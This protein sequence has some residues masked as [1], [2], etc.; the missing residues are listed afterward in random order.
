[1]AAQPLS[2]CGWPDDAA[3]LGGGELALLD[4]LMPTG[5]E[6][7]ASL[8]L[9]SGGEGSA[10]AHAPAAPLRCLDPSHAA[11]CGLCLAP[12]PEGEEALYQLRAACESQGEGDGAGPSG[13][14]RL[15]AQLLATAEWNSAPAR[16]ALAAAEEARGDPARVAL[17]LRRKTGKALLKSHMLLMVRAWGY[18]SDLWR[19]RGEAGGR[20]KRSRPASDEAPPRQASGA[21]A[22]PRPPGCLLEP[23]SLAPGG[24]P[25]AL[26]ALW[27]PSAECFLG[28]V[29]REA[30]TRAGVAFYN[31]EIDSE[32]AAFDA[33]TARLGAE[34]AKLEA[35]QASWSAAMR[36]HLTAT[37]AASMDDV[38]ARLALPEGRLPLCVAAP[39]S[40]LDTVP[41]EAGAR[42]LLAAAA[43]LEAAWVERRESAQRALGDNSSLDMVAVDA[44]ARALY[45]HFR[46]FVAEAL[47]VLH[48]LAARGSCRDY[49]DAAAD[50]ARELA[51]FVD[52]ARQNMSD[53]RAW[54]ARQCASGALRPLSASVRPHEY[55]QV[56][57]TLGDRLLA[58]HVTP[59]QLHGAAC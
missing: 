56:L 16:D 5:S 41:A 27:R 54:Y 23:L 55:K 17:L 40:A 1:M 58:V 3:A 26:R 20:R 45:S 13:S 50:V 48:F 2:D 42:C 52:Q 7:C 22:V 10:P 11:G 57:E 43:S 25:S 36:M 30:C 53:Q 8:E 39:C 14:A 49:L 51:R 35:A 9:A 31:A 15:R 4:W 34:L 12:P 28:S 29:C 19:R 18:A 46:R 47:L 6:H 21:S 37:Q 44:E 33:G 59:V 24:Q 32:F 38:A